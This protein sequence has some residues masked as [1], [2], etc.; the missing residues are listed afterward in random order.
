MSIYRFARPSWKDS[1]D[2]LPGMVFG[3]DAPGKTEPPP[4]APVTTAPPPAGPYVPPF[5]RPGAA[6]AAQTSAP[7]AAL[8]EAAMSACRPPPGF[9]SVSPEQRAQNL[10]AL[11]SG[12]SSGSGSP[13][14]GLYDSM[15][16]GHHDR[17]PP[18]R[19]DAPSF[20]C[21]PPSRPSIGV[22]F[23][24]LLVA[25]PV[26][27][28]CGRHRKD[29][30]GPPPSAELLREVKSLHLCNDHHLLEAC[31]RGDACSSRH[32]KEGL[33]QDHRWALLCVAR[34]RICLRGPHCNVVGC[35]Y[36]HHCTYRDANG[37]CRYGGSTEVWGR[38]VFS[39]ALHC[40]H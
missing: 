2:D 25:P 37:R 35:V 27:C 40:E 15:V 12:P 32:M 13:P 16:W 26:T 30:A 33:P 7:P 21:S 36:D 5:R 23:R 4:P 28:P 24:G 22:H 14:K 18:L 6:Q 20:R 19:A 38:C 9:E 31:P 3:E 29:F 34:Q 17:S 8:P 10:S 39:A 11:H 1:W